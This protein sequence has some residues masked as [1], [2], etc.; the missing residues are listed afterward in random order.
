MKLYRVETESVWQEIY[1]S[2]KYIGLTEGRVYAFNS[3]KN[4]PFRSGVHTPKS[5]VVIVFNDP[6]GNLFLPHPWVMGLWGVWKRLSGQYVSATGNICF[7]PANISY[8]DREIVIHN[9]WHEQHKTPYARN[10][11]LLK[12]YWRWLFEILTQALV[13][14]MVLSYVYD[15]LFPDF[16][17][18]LFLIWAATAVVT[19]AAIPIFCLLID[20]AV[21]RKER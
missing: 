14:V 4:N 10:V 13:L 5:S 8:Q 17:V 6:H 12:K 16:Y 3:A 20:P 15:F 2:G 9:A 19:A 7:D 18:A 21:I 11:G 1:R